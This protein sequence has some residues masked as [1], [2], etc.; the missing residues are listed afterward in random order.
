ML[1]TF[2]GLILAIVVLPIAAASINDSPQSLLQALYRVHDQG[3]G[4]LLQ[5]DAKAE[6]RRFF[7]PA[8]AAALDAELN[9]PDAEE[10]V[11]NLDFDPF[12]N[13]QETELGELDF[14]V[15][16][17]SG[18]EVTAVARFSNFGEPMLIFYRL[19]QDKDGWRIDDIEYG[20]GNTLRKVLRGE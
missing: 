15:P 18:K 11:G 10:E 20:E 9:R 19:V 2:F 3:Q 12:Y 14:A 6:R 16:K 1:R 13:A 5:P 17:V 8:L 4:P 7:T